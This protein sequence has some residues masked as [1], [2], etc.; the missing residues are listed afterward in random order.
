VQEELPIE[1]SE[2]N[3]RKG[4]EPAQAGSIDARDWGEPVRE[5]ELSAGDLLYL[6]RGVPHSAVTG[7][8]CSVHL[9]IGLRPLLMEAVL[10]ELIRSVVSQHAHWRRAVTPARDGGRRQVPSIQALAAQLAEN[11]CALGPIEPLIETLEEQLLRNDEAVG[12]GPGGYLR[13]LERLP[14]LQLDSE[15]ECRPGHSGVLSRRGEEAVVL[16]FT[17]GAME[18]PA[19]CEPAFRYILER[20]RF[21]IRDLPETLTAEAKVTLCHRLVREG[22]LSLGA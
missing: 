4:R 16:T 20:S 7:D 13:S 11:L 1:G 6:P 21:R 15:L 22:L 5:I 2:T 17:G 12:L 8:S 3:P 18:A 19:F 9:T 10:S 14:E